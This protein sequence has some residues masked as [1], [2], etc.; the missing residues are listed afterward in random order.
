M[1]KRTNR[2]Y[3][4]KR[5]TRKRKGG[6]IEFA[7]TAFVGTPW[8]PE[9]NQWPSGINANHYKLNTYDK[10]LPSYNTLQ[11]GGKKRKGGTLAWEALGFNYKSLWNTFRTNQA[12][13]NPAPFVQPH[14]EKQIN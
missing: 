2:R 5:H 3:K 13:T 10:T 11:S 12:P 14:L 4:K 9:P 6:N 7:K 8:G 1:K